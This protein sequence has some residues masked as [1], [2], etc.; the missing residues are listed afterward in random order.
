M[1]RGEVNCKWPWPQYHQK[2]CDECCCDLSCAWPWSDCH[3]NGC[4]EC[5]CDLSKS[6]F[7]CLKIA[8]YKTSIFLP[9]ILYF[10]V[11]KTSAV[12]DSYERFGIGLQDTH[13]C[14]DGDF[15]ATAKMTTVKIV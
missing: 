5:Y 11:L 9:P 10:L 3:R 14:D 7:F 12:G 6:P 15:F 4:D 13:Y 8:S 2:R 1:S